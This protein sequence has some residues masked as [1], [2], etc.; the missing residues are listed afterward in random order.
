MPK[1]YFSHDYNTRNKKRLATLI[2]FEKMKGYGTFWVIVEMLHEDSVKW[3][4]LSEETFVAISRET[5]QDLKFIK[6]FIRKCIDR[7]KVFIEDNNFFTSERVLDNVDKRLK[8]S[9]V[10]SFAGKKSAEKRQQM[11]TSVEQVSTVAQQSPTKESKGNEIKVNSIYIYP[12]PDFKIELSD[13]QIGQATEYLYHTKKISA[14]REMILSIWGV[15]KTKNLTGSSPYKDESDIISH[16]LNSLKFEQLNGTP[17]H[18]KPPHGGGQRKSSDGLELLVNH[19][20]GEG[21]GINP[22]G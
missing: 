7:Y 6:N 10:R 12:G 11:S 15:F 5:G 14:S 21:P 20:T 8:I 19:I 4:E 17:T 1:E 22:G 3:M 16:F 9:E 2:H 18:R 13:V